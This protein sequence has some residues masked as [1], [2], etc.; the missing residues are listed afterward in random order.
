MGMEIGP[1]AVVRERIHYGSG[2]G[3]AAAPRGEYNI[4][5][6]GNCIGLCECA[7][8]CDFTLSFDAFQQHVVEGR[9]AIQA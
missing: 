8:E 2:D 1:K 9:I 4:E 6:R 7:G 5:A 3:R